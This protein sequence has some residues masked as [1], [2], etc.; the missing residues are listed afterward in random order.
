MPTY[1]PEQLARMSQ[2]DLLAALPQLF[3]ENQAA[4]TAVASRLTAAEEALAAAPAGPD[5]TLRFVGSPGAGSLTVTVTDGAGAAGVVTF[6]NNAGFNAPTRTGAGAASVDIGGGLGN[7]KD[8]L[9]TM[10]AHAV[11]AMVTAGDLAVE[12]K[13][14]I[15]TP[16]VA[17][18]NI[19]VE[20]AGV[21]LSIT[22]TSGEGPAV[23]ARSAALAS[24]I[25]VA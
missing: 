18:T 5:A 14:V 3:A 2:P 23:A 21:S 1:T 15:D 8:T 20:A 9:A 24:A 7:E 17:T 19:N 25:E 16:R 13:V 4:D 11:R 10:V 22:D 12:V 6:A